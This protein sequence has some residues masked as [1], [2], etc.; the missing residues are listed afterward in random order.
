MIYLLN[1]QWLSQK[2]CSPNLINTHNMA[3]AFNQFDEQDDVLMM[4]PAPGKAEFGDE[5]SGATSGYGDADDDEFAD[6]AIEEDSLETDM[7]DDLRGDD[8]DDDDL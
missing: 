8:I 5:G 2:L 3:T 7:D 4:N 6:D 1:N